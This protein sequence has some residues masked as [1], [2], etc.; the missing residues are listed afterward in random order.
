MAQLV[1]ER[2]PN[3]GNL[4]ASALR[5]AAEADN[6]LAKIIQVCR[7]LQWLI[8]GLITNVAYFRHQLEAM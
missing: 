5:E 1:A 7:L 8:P 3:P 6:S 2:R 4:S